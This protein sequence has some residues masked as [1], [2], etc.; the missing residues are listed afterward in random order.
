MKEHGLI[1]DGSFQ[2]G[3]FE[4]IAKTSDTQEYQLFNV[5]ILNQYLVNSKTKR[6]LHLVTAICED[7]PADQIFKIQTDY[8]FVN[9]EAIEDIWI[10]DRYTNIGKA[11]VICE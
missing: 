6:K 9:I 2:A 7:G 10:S 8:K 11:R 1:L 4:I 3:T 5:R